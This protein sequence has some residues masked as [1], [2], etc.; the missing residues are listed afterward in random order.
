MNS[1]R[2]FMLIFP[3][4]GLIFSMSCLLLHFSVDTAQ[5]QKKFAR[6]ECLDCHKKFGDKYFG[7]KSVHK[8]VKENKC[9]DCHQRH[10]I[11]PRLMLKESGNELCF[12]CHEKG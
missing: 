8:V 12:K 1:L 6:K 4:V 9:E 11:V 7:L 10:G 3:A 5:A 2:K